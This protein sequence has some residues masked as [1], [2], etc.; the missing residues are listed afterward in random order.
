MIENEVEAHTSYNNTLSYHGFDM[1]HKDFLATCHIWQ[2][3][4]N[5]SVR[6][7]VT[8]SGSNNQQVITNPCQHFP[9]TWYKVHTHFIQFLQRMFHSDML[10]D[11]LECYPQWY[12]YK[13]VEKSER[14]DKN[15]CRNEYYSGDK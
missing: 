3:I 4:D 15:T 5:Y 6:I 2:L 9:V 12:H 13:Y 1:W 10:F 14:M 7:G 8:T 11:K